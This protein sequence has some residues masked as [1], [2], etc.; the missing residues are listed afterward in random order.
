MDSIRYIMTA[1]AT[2]LEANRIAARAAQLVR[3]NPQYEDPAYKD[4]VNS[5]SSQ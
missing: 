5:L 3:D 1:L 4:K 2:A